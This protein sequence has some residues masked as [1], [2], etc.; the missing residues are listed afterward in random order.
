MAFRGQHEHSLDA[1]DR[2]TIPARFRAALDEGVVLFEELDDCVSI[3][4]VSE[5]AELTRNYLGALNPLTKQGRMMRRRFHARSHDEKLDSAGRVRLPK[6]LIEHAGLSG[7]CMVVGVD[8]HLE[9]WEPVAWA[10]H[11]AEI[12]A[13]ADAFAESLGGADE[14]E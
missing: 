10:E 9:V 1:K 5:Y 13:K 11:D 2:L 7:A 6:H 14:G 3:Y 12:D 8:D 4:P